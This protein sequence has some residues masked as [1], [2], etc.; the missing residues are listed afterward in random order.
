MLRRALSDDRLADRVRAGDDAAFEVLYDRHHRQLLAFCRHMVGDRMEAEDVLQ[1]VFVAAYRML[2]E[3]ARE[4][5]VKA[6]LYAVARN[7]CLSVLR[8][9]RDATQA[10]DE[11]LPSLDGLPAQV[12]R[13][14]DLRELVLDLQR[15]PDDQRAALVLAELGALSHDE[16]ASVLG[17]N[18]Q[19]VKALVF[20]ARE[21]LMQRRDAREVPCR[22]IQEQLAT[23]RGGALRRSHLRRHVEDCPA[24]AAFG[25]EVR[26][27]RAAMAALLPVVPGATLKAGV[28]GS[29]VGG[30]G[31]GAAVIAGGAG[32]GALAGAGAALEGV[33]A[34]V[35][36]SAALIGG[37]GAGGYAA[38]EG[39]DRDRPT[40]PSSQRA[41]SSSASRSSALQDRAPGVAFA[42]PPQ[43]A[44]AASVP[45]AQAP[46]RS[47]PRRSATRKRKAARRRPARRPVVA[48][49]AVQT[50]PIPVAATPVAVPVAAR[51]PVDSKVGDARDDRVQARKP[52]R[53]NGKGRGDGDAPA[54]GGAPTTSSGSPQAT[55]QSQARGPQRRA[56]KRRRTNAGPAPAPA[57]PAAAPSG[58]GGESPGET[59]RSGGG[60]PSSPDSGA[61]SKPETP[62]DGAGQPAGSEGDRDG[63]GS[64][65]GGGSKGGGSKGGGGS[66][67]GD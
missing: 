40:P 63:G 67:G 34:K 9:R 54:A 39:L 58:G 35:L 37:T 32:I 25:A 24:C 27:Q 28:L 26:R 3:D 29:A 2:S 20:Q 7:R 4:L 5:H 45:A 55:S 6:W 14:A 50:S 60:V 43:P 11:Q 62:R 47:Q 33:A 66:D 41:D 21:H 46:A 16:I 49:P 65:G 10:L 38:I 59:T 44:P 22:E 15:L 18:A 8:A 23:L 53:G 57:A 51:Q 36:L 19:K 64:T 31:A 13:R 1:H 12:Q 48:A 30:T 56:T 42:A 52:Q 17:V 61:D